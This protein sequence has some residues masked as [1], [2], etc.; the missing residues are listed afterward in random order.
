MNLP[1]SCESKNPDPSNQTHPESAID[2]NLG[3]KVA[4]QWV[5]GEFEVGVHVR[6]SKPIVGRQLLVDS[7]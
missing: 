6:K 1:V 7:S 3:L 2:P 4:D 5:A